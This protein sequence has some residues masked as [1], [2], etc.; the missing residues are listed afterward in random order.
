MAF[1][2]E[3]TAY[4]KFKICDLRGVILCCHLSNLISFYVDLL[5]HHNGN[6]SCCICQKKTLP[7]TYYCTNRLTIVLT[8]HL[9][10]L[11]KKRFEC[12]I[13]F[14]NQIDIKPGAIDEIEATVDGCQGDNAHVR[15]ASGGEKCDDSAQFTA[16]MAFSHNVCASGRGIHCRERT[17]CRN[18]L[19]TSDALIGPDRTRVSRC[20]SRRQVTRKDSEATSKLR[21][22]YRRTGEPNAVIRYSTF[23]SIC[24][25]Q[26]GLIAARIAEMQGTRSCL[27]AFL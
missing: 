14:V 12:T 26:L 1:K 5:M 3:G 18:T 16:W 25:L 9:S 22:N 6:S 11:E 15:H 23:V 2:E 8:H 4:H 21:T 20:T 17:A 24:D 7:L 10:K 27:V 19:L 13:D